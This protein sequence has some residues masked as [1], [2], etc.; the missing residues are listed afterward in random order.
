MIVASAFP[1]LRKY[2][3][4]H[5]GL[6]GFSMQAITP[7]LAAG[8]GLSQTSGV[9]VSDVTPDGAADAAGIGTRTLWPQ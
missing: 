1:Q 6:A 2:G 5:R 7:A 3:H 4:L 9:M 8:L